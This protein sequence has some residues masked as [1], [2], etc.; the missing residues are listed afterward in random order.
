MKIARGSFSIENLL[1]SML[2]GEIKYDSEDGIDDLFIDVIC[3]GNNN[4][5]E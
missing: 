4:I 3:L 2:I 5:N 1:L